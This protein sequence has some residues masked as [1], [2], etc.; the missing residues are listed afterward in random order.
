MLLHGFPD[1]VEGWD[2]VARQLGY[3]HRVFSPD[4]SGYNL[5]DR[6]AD[7]G[8]YVMSKLVADVKAVVE[9]AHAETGEPVL[10]VGHD[11]GAVPMFAFAHEHPELIKGIVSINGVHPD[12][13][14]REFANNPLQRQAFYYVNLFS[15]PGVEFVLPANGGRRR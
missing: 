6:P 8:A 1:G 5:S 12:V 4:L 3:D 10:L 11:W 9:L 7:P 14:R 13:L 2:Y 15:T